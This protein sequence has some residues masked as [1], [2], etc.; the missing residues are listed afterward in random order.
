MFVASTKDILLFRQTMDFDPKNLE[1]LITMQ[2][3]SV[4]WY[5]TFSRSPPLLPNTFGLM[6]VISSAS[7]KLSVDR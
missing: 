5:L 3:L 1:L 2:F 7:P 4:V 6:E